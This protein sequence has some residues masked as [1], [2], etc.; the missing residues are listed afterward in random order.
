MSNL[1][2]QREEIFSL[3]INDEN[4]CETA[5]GKL[6]V[7]CK[8]LKASLKKDLGEGCSSCRKSAIYSKYRQI[9]YAKLI[10]QGK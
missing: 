6:M 7:N 1:E 4:F 9:I 5:H 10:Q 2:F 3:F 8:D